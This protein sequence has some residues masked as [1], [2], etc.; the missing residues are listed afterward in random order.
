MFAKFLLSVGIVFLPLYLGNS[1]GVQLSHGLIAIACAIVLVT[2]SNKLRPYDGVLGFLVF[3][4]FLRESIQIFFFNAPLSGVMPSVYLLFNFLLLI[5]GHNII[6]RD[7]SRNY[8][9]PALILGTIIAVS[10]VLFTGFN[11]TVDQEFGRGIGTFNNPNQLGYFAVCT[12][13]IAVL[14]YLLGSAGMTILGGL[15]LCSIFLAIASLSKAAMVG[16]LFSTTLLGY[17]LIPPGKS[18]AQ[19]GLLLVALVC[20]A[21]YLI[22]TSATYREFSFVVRLLDIGSDSD[23]NLIG[24]G[25]NLATYMNGFEVAFGLSDFKA[26]LIRGSEVHSTIG[27]VFINYGILGG[28]LFLLFLYM[29]W[30]KLFKNFGLVSSIIVAGPPMLYGLTHN[31]I[32]FTIFWILIALT[33]SIKLRSSD[34]LDRPASFKL[35]GS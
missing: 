24:R 4:I 25:Y 1:G 17:G 27:W 8:L 19:F 34:Y 13:S 33:F 18:R 10:G 16:I 3:F 11:F 21:L 30:W 29:W 14:L 28:G 7:F 15:V 23:D 32:R 5:I 31:G 9:L 35:A 2:R 22:L 26:K 12:F 6:D 20:V